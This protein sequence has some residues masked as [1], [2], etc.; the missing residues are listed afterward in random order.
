MNTDTLKITLAQRILSLNDLSLLEKVKNLLK[1]D[2]VICYTVAGKPLT[3]A[4]FTSEMESQQNKIK[5]GTAKLHSVE[6]VRK[7]VMNEI[8]LGR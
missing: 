6:N 2:D 4:E 7:I 5:N 3:K 8:N 1:S